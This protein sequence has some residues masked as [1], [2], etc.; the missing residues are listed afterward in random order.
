[1]IKKRVINPLKLLSMTTQPHIELT[2][3]E[4]AVLKVASPSLSCME[5]SEIAGVNYLQAYRCIRKFNLE[6]K[7][8]NNERKD[9]K[10]YTPIKQKNKLTIAHKIE[11]TKSASKDKTIYD[12]C[13]LIK[14][15]SYDVVWRFCTK[16]KLPYKMKWEAKREKPKPKSNVF[17]WEDFENSVL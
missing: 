2:T 13:K 6:I 15:G 16:H 1:M 5:I 14:C 17:R 4:K 10:Q 8:K 9:P 12:L 11:L 3:A 7:R